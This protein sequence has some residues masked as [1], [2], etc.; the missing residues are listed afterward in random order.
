MWRLCIQ[1]KRVTANQGPQD[2]HL[3][4]D[5][6]F[7]AL[8]LQEVQ[9]DSVGMRVAIGVFAVKS[10]FREK[11]LINEK[12][13]FSLAR[14]PGVTRR[15]YIGRNYEFRKCKRAPPQKELGSR[16]PVAPST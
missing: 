14:R 4:C 7:S 9:R 15:T 8:S 5:G 16:P 1:G 12:N 11:G 6:A 2:K 10:E 3:F 13:S